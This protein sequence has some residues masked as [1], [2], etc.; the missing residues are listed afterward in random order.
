MTA[1]RVPS[2]ATNVVDVVAA[3]AAVNNESPE[4]LG[5]PPSKATREEKKDRGTV[6]TSCITVVWFIIFPLHLG[7]WAL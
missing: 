3:E 6:I 2:V 7:S 5:S 1:R 4:S